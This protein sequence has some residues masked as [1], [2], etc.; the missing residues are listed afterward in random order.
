MTRLINVKF[1]LG[2]FVWLACSMVGCSFSSRRIE[3]AIDPPEITIS[4]MAAA[5]LSEAFTEM[6]ALFEDEHPNVEVELNFAGSQQ[7]A[8][9][10]TQGAVADVYASANQKQMD[11]VIRAGR[12]IKQD[13]IIFALNRLVVIYP[14]D[15]PGGIQEIRDLTRPGLKLVF[16]ASEVPVGQYSLEFLDKANQD[17]G[18]E[19]D[20]KKNVLANIVSYEEN[21][22]AVLTK[23]ALGEADAGIVYTSD[24]TGNVNNQVGQIPILDAHNVIAVYPI[25][26]IKDSPQN[27]TAQAFVKLVLSSKGQA[28]LKQ[29]GFIPAASYG[30]L[31]TD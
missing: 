15:N 22:K 14:R 31:E 10:L 13:V 12:V 23:V 18:F 26:H 24:V 11:E 20:F 9:Q 5:S 17:E 3:R 21:V 8:Q 7:L 19:A 6:G 4:V 2:I 30:Q 29:H 16:A 1:R 25:A 28:L 27:D